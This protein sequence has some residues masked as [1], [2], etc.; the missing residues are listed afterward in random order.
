VTAPSPPVLDERGPLISVVIPVHD[1]AR[2]LASAIASAVGQTYRPIE[3]IVVDDGSTDDSAAIARTVPGVRVIS[4]TQQGPAAA[5][6]TGIRESTGGLVA[7]LDSDD[8][9]LPGKLAAQAGYL[10]QHPG[11]GYVLCRLKNI[12]V[13]GTARPPWLNPLHL[14][15]DPVAESL[16]AMLIRRAVLDDVGLLDT[17]YP[18][19]EDTDWFMRAR[20]RG[21]EAGCVDA[22]LV[23]RRVHA[24]NLSHRAPTLR[25]GIMMRIARS[26]IARRK[27]AQPAK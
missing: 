4:Q 16:C 18:I 6:N 9:W 27:S 26:S 17:Q 8:T 2:Y 7:F 22:V 23:H 11:V 1:G 3:I 24:A 19:G 25:A 13:E 15:T 14:A 12:L 20:D 10:A 21:I 5:R